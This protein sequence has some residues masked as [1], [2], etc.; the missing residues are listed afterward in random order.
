MIV[1]LITI[2]SRLRFPRLRPLLWIGACLLSLSC[3]SI[4]KPSAVTD[5]RL[6]YDQ[7]AKNWN[8]ALPLGNGRLGAMIFGH[9]AQEQLQLRSE[10]HTSEL[11]SRE[12]LVCRLLLEKKKKRIKKHI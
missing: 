7:P 5:F 6:W 3:Q 4:H 10:E 1:M 2:F 12:N 9:P 11:Q 8:Y